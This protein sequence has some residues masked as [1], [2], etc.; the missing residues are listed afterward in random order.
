MCKERWIAANANL[1]A[2]PIYARNFLRRSVGSVSRYLLAPAC[3]IRIQ[4]DCGAIT[5]CG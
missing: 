2:S 1:F 4:I 5:L 3:D